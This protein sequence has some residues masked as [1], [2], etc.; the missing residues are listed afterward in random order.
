MKR[1]SKLLITPIVAA[2]LLAGCSGNGNNEQANAGNSKDNSAAGKPETW[3]ADRTIKGLVFMDSDI[4]TE[5]NPE[6]AAELKKKTGITL[7]MQAVQGGD[8]T[9]LL[10]AGIASGDLPDFIAYYLD[11]SGRPEMAVIL[12]AAAE[13][14]FTDLTPLFK[15][16]KIYSKYMEEGYLPKDTKYGSMFRPEFNGS[17][18]LAHMNIWRQPGY[19]VRKYVAGPYIRKDIA[20]ALKIDPREIRTTEQFYELAKKIKAGGFKDKNGKDVYPIGPDYHGGR[21]DSSLYADLVW[22]ENDQLIKR[23]ADGKIVHESQTEYPMKRVAYMQK[24]LSEKLMDPE[25]FTMEETRATEGALNGSYAIIGMHNYMDF[26]KDEHYLPMG[27]MNTTD[28]PYQM[29]VPY[30]TAYGAWSIPATTEHPEEVVKFA[31]FLASR[32]GK[33]LWQYGIEGRDYT[34]D[35]KGNPIVKQE[36]LDVVKNDPDQGKK[37]GFEVAGNT[38]GE[39]LGATDKDQLVDF[40][41]M[42]YGD[43]VNPE[44]NAAPERMAEYWGWDKLRSNARLVDGYRPLSFLSVFAKGEQLQ[45]ALDNYKDSMI[46]AYYTKSLDEAKKIVDSASA[47]LN[48]AGLDEYLTLIDQ[49]DKDVKTKLIMQ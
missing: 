9:E 8:S 44:L 49:K 32:E 3:I 2:L 13:G 6:I 1:W 17:S 48:A 45:A 16:T 26:N 23:D 15:D 41:E 19:N 4:D 31:D 47:Q 37:L 28:G 34:L 7:E 5:M 40:G 42:F 22:G 36:V 24:L 25:F 20:E 46:R 12:K 29:M 11:N 30:K 33:L 18:Y 38:W 10:A 35:E 43:S 27:P 14:M 21:E 39:P